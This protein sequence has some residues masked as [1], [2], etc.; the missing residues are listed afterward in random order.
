MGK[1]AS[2]MHIRTQ[3]MPANSLTKLCY[4]HQVDLMLG[5]GRLT[6]DST[7]VTVRPASL[8]SAAGIFSEEDLLRGGLEHRFKA[9]HE[10]A[11]RSSWPA[12]RTSV[13]AAGV[14]KGCVPPSPLAEDLSKAKPRSTFPVQQMGQDTFPPL[15]DQ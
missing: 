3:V 7:E 6:M 15:R 5:T 13:R 10:A 14:G 1:T 2:T 12:G 4:S 8:A 9:A 11:R